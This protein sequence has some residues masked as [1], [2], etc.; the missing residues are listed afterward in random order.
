MKKLLEYINE[1]TTGIYNTAGIY[2]SV[3]IPGIYQ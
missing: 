3:N 2:H 1:N